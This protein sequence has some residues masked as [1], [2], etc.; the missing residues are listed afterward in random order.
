MLDMIRRLLEP[1]S[2]QSSQDAKARLKFLL[3]HD[4]VDLT[5]AQVEKLKAEIM[6]VIARYVDVEESDVDFRLDKAGGRIA[7]VSNVPVR[8][9][10]ARSA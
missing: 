9:V 2:T 6:E 3:V 7:L 8:R 4:E 1:K 5:P 10:T